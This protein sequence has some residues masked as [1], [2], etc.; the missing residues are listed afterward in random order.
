VEPHEIFIQLAQPH[1]AAILHVATALIGPA[2]AE[3]AAQEALLRGMRSW[4]TL[5]DVGALHTWLLRITYNVCTDWRRGRFG[6]ARRLTQPLP[7]DDE[8]LALALLGEGPGSSDHAAALD[9]RAAISRLDAGLRVV[10]ALRYYANVDATD[11][12]AM[13]HLPASTVRTRLRRALS[14]LRSDL[15]LTREVTTA[16]EELNHRHEQRKGDGDVDT[17]QVESTH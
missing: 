4:G 8:E 13:L 11:I 14:V 6:T 3:D 16:Q 2:D 15:S 17:A 5:R 9:L 7:E 12:G 10:V 1:L